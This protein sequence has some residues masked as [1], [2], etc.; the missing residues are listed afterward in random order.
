MV[1]EIDKPTFT[2][3]LI[4]FAQFARSKGLN[5]GVEETFTALRAV[6]LGVF[7]NKAVFYYT[8]KAI[9]CCNKDDLPLFNHLF[10]IY[11]ETKNDD[12]RKKSQHKIINPQHLPKQ[13]SVLSAW[14]LGNG[15]QKQ[16]EDSKTVTGG[17]ATVRLRKT[18]FSKVAEMD[19]SILEDIAEKLWREMS[20]RLKRRMKR[21]HTRETID[22]RRTIRASLQHG[23][24]P[25]ELRHRGKKPRKMRLVILLDVSGSMDKYSFFLLRFVWA[26]QSYFEQVES[27]VFSTQLRCI[28]ETL[29][30]K[31]LEK[32]LKMLTPQADNWSSGTKIGECLK[33]FNDQYASRILTRSSMVVVLSDGLDTG[34]KGVLE[35]EI[36]KIRRKT[37]RLIWL[38]PLKG[39]TNYEPS[40]RGM[41]EALPYVDYFRSAHNL[42]SMLELEDLLCSL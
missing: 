19:A 30:T 2:R 37:R 22:L 32:T 12:T 3:A 42:E 6:D 18:D 9:F 27:F 8:L 17:N 16:E 41:S 40:A 29:K 33:T 5:V 28:T 34:E 25:I 20:K 39:M 7:E 24:D 38:N 10:G 4:G 21:R 1:M 36:Q 35:A 15:E 11:W 26:L 31:G 13:Q 23:G 14:G